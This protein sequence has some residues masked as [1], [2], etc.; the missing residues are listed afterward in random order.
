MIRPIAQ[1]QNNEH[2]KNDP[3]GFI[4]GDGS[5]QVKMKKAGRHPAGGRDRSG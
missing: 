2:P 4:F 5:A 1:Q 3:R